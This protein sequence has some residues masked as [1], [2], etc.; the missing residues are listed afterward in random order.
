VLTFFDTTSLRRAEEQAHVSEDQLRRAAAAASDH[1]IVVAD[2]H[3]IVTGWNTGAQS[4]F[5]YDAG[6]MLGQSIARI[7]LP[8]DVEAGVP[9][10]EM[11]IAARKGSVTEDRWHLARDGSRVFCSGSLTAFASGGNRGFVKIVRDATVR[12]NAELQVSDRLRTAIAQRAEMENVS[13]L[14]DDFIAVISHELKNP[15]NLISVNAE[16]LARDPAVKRAENAATAVDAIRGAVRGQTKIID[17]L[18]D[19]SR[20]RTGK[21]T[22]AMVPVDL[23]G[24]VESIGDIAAADSAASGLSIRVH[25]WHKPAIVNADPHRLDQIVW[26]LLSN[27]IKFT[28]EGGTIDI[29]VSQEGGFVKLTVSDT[30]CGIDA[31]FLTRIFD[32]FGQAPGRSLRG[33]TGLG[34]GLHLVRQLVDRHGGRIRVVSDGPGKGATFTVWLPRFESDPALRPEGPREPTGQRLSDLHLL[35]VEDSIDAAGALRL[36]LELEG[37]RVSVAHDGAAALAAVQAERPDL[38]ISDIGMPGLNGYDFVST[39]RATPET[40]DLPAVALTGFG[41]LQDIDHALRAGFDAHVA[42]PVLIDDLVAQLLAVLRR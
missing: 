28:P 32:L 18:L 8:E 10:L 33:R 36:L 41:R 25:C 42:K 2:D 19:M 23:N 22:L 37:A 5:G 9:Q 15:L 30:G 34:I 3:G 38:V 27:A 17:D 12:H 7:F 13:E 40:A 39:L 26:N 16:I 6:E 31:H 29:E 14:K 20:I 1:A 35:V 24:V 21:F 11:D 4:I